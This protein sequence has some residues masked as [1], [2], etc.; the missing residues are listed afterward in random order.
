MGGD[1]DAEVKLLE[2]VAELREMQRG[3]LII[4]EFADFSNG[5]LGKVIQFLLRMVKEVV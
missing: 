3:E 5:E 2:M 1:G 4:D